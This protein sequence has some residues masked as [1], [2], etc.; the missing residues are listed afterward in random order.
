MTRSLLF[1]FSV[2]FAAPAIP[3]QLVVVNQTP[4]AH[5]YLVLQHDAGQVLRTAV[6]IFIVGRAQQ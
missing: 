6:A 2:L 1:V 5:R 4:T 3:E